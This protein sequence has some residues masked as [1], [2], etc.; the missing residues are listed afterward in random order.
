M[1]SMIRQI[2]SERTLCQELTVDILHATI[3]NALIDT[4]LSTHDAHAVRE[5]TFTM[6]AVVWVLLAMNLYTLTMLD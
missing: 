6:T 3:T 2:A 5:R 4:V 1:G